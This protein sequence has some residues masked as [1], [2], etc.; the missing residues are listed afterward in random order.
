MTWIKQIKT[1]QIRGKGMEQKEILGKM[2]LEDKI[3]LCSGADFWHTKEMK[4]YGIPSI[5]MTDGPHGLRKQEDS[6]M[7]ER[8]L[9]EIYLS[10]FET[11]VKEGRP[12]AV[13]CAYNKVNG[14]HCSDSKALIKDILRREWGF[15]GV[16]V[17]DWG[18]MRDRIRAFEAGCDLC[19]PGG[20]A[21][22]E[23]EA[24]AAVGSGNLKEEDVDRSALRILNLVDRASKVEFG[25]P[26]DMEAHFQLTKRAAGESAVL[27]KNEGNLLPVREKEGIVFL[28]H[29]AEKMR[30]QGAGSSHINP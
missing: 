9:R 1:C 26:A 8:T 14:E 4:Q 28:G 20:S 13:M 21:Y 18:A 27:L 12:S 6:V 22:M 2:T 24:F 17:T 7:D 16:V 11:A 10:G 29:M 5:L 25:V 30:Y 19:M 3:Q 23:A 15:E